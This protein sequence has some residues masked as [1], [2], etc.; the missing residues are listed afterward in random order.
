MD[1][2]LENDQYSNTSI[3]YGTLDVFSKSAIKALEKKAL[4]FYIKNR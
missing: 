3:I 1:R 4:F 2:C